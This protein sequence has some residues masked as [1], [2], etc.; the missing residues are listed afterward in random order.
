MLAGSV[1]TIDLDPYIIDWDDDHVTITM[2]AGTAAIFT[3][4]KENVIT[5]APEK[6]AI[7]TLYTIELILND[8]WF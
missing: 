1:L 2:K 8:G 4:I 7:D 6:T 5:I 3:K